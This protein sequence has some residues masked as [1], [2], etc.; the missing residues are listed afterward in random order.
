MPKPKTQNEEFLSRSGMQQEGSQRG[1]LLNIVP[2]QKFQGK[3]SVKTAE[4]KKNLIASHRTFIKEAILKW[5][6]L[7]GEDLEILDPEL[8]S[9]SPGRN[10]MKHEFSNWGQV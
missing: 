7:P 10:S 9:Y 8:I 4:E 3:V 2:R 5:N 6:F 1:Q